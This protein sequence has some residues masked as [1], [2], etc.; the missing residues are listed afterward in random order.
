MLPSNC[1]GFAF[2]TSLLTAFAVT[3]RLL[4]VGCPHLVQTFVGPFEAERLVEGIRCFNIAEVRCH[5]VHNGM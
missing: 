1:I 3:R 2:Y 5:R 4:T